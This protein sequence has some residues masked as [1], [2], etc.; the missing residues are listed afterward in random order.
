MAQA[1]AGQAVDA[2]LEFKQL[3]EAAPEFGG[4][5][6][7]L[8]VLL[9]GQNRLEEAEAALRKRC[10]ATPGSALALTE[11]GLVQRERGNFA[12]AARVLRAAL[13][14]RC[15]T[16]RLRMRNLGVLRDLYHGDPAAALRSL[17]AVPGAHRRG[18]AGDELDRGRE[19][20]RRRA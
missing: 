10:A 7:N 9:R 11:L 8:G 18:P 1:N 12:A 3:M 5:A 2:E 17:R 14:G 4:A 16:M 15:R 20:A 13:A 19:A 6:Y